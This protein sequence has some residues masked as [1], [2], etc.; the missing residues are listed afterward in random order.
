MTETNTMNTCSEREWNDCES[1]R[2]NTC[3]EW[4]W[5]DCES[6][7]M[8]TCSEWEWN[9]CESNGNLKGNGMTVTVMAFL[10]GP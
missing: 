9:D 3:S 1:N 7:R 4:E 5:N 2:M 10:K 6:N 8:N